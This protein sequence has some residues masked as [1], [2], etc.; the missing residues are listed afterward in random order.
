MKKIAFLFLLFA[1]IS[2]RCSS[3]FGSGMSEGTIVYEI[4]YLENED[5]NPLISLLPKTMTLHFKNNNTVSKIE[6]YL[7]LFEFAF[8]N[9]IEEQINATLLKIL[10]KKFMY[11]TIPGKA[12]FGYDQMQGV[13]IEML[14]QT[15][16]ILGYN[17]QLARV[18]YKNKVPFDMYFT[19]EINIEKPNQSNPFKKI[20]GVLLDFQI[21]LNNINMRLLAKSITEE[22]ISPKEFAVP[23]E[24]KKVSKDDMQKIM[25]KYIPQKKRKDKT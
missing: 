19:H 3:P 16:I 17:C 9:N 24:Y 12:S 5:D 25:D 14:N 23:P 11:Q 6:G 1:L 22:N 4:Y 8:I 18:I 7:G 13:E 10:D 15:K 20:D 2:V 21:K